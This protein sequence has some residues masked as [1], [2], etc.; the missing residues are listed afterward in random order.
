MGSPVVRASGLHSNDFSRFTSDFKTVNL[1]SLVISPIYFSQ[2][3]I[4]SNFTNIFSVNLKSLVISPITQF[5]LFCS[6]FHSQLRKP[7]ADFELSGCMY[8]L[9][10]L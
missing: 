10:S 8:A 9:E 3:E 5:D 1:K 2:S 7:K 6:A 4:T